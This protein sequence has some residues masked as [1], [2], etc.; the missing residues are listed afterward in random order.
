MKHR[1]LALLGVAV[2]GWLSATVYA[3]EIITQVVMPEQ[4]QTMPTPAQTVVSEGAV[5]SSEAGAFFDC[6][7]ADG[8]GWGSFVAGGGFYILQPRFHS[9]T[10][11]TSTSI[12]TTNIDN[13]TTSVTSITDSNF[14]YN[15]SIAPRWWVGYMS[16]RGCGIR[17]RN[18]SFQQG[19][20]AFGT[21]GPTQ[22]DNAVTTSTGISTQR[23]L[24]LG[25]DAFPGEGGLPEQVA[26]TSNLRLNVWDYE[27]VHLFQPGCWSVLCAGGVRYA[28]VGQSYSAYRNTT[29]GETSSSTSPLGGPGTITEASSVLSSGHTFNGAGPT[30]G[31][32]ARRR[33]GCTCLSVYGGLRG[34]ILFGR[35]IQR[36]TLRSTTVGMLE[37]EIPVNQV[38]IQNATSGYV[39][40]VLPVGELELGVDCTKDIGK[41]TLFLQTGFV[42][43]VWFDAGNASSRDGNLGFVGLS[44][45]AGVH[46]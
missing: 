27:A 23:P 46:F 7:T 40:D 3:Q 9:N 11:L 2:F 42:S 38:S 35:S 8:C 22:V 26:V 37:N 5:A 29:P 33:L 32:E 45:T 41:A 18:W 4:I 39:N 43:Q 6:D 24:G 30:F 13:I 20:Q 16:A 17:V 21:A 1:L 15:M 25:I 12:T 19:Q 10:A 31:I 44:V 36:A 28:F 34:S 14:N